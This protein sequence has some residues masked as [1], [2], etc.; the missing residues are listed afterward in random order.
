ML[1]INWLAIMLLFHVGPEV[2]ELFLLAD[3]GMRQAEGARR[4]GVRR[5]S[6]WR[7]GF[8]TAPTREERP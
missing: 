5:E 7:I 3:F 2:Q 6:L 8:C 1:S 4:P